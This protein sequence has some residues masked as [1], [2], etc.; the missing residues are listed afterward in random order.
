MQ[1]SCDASFRIRVKIVAVALKWWTNVYAVWHYIGE[2]KE[3][4]DT[5]GL[6]DFF[7]R[8]STKGVAIVIPAIY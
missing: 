4:T 8:I 2:N 1:I 5:N 7:V 6:M 3:R